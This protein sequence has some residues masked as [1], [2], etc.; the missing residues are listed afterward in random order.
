MNHK[1]ILM[2]LLSVQIFFLGCSE[3]TFT[4][5][6]TISGTERVFVITLNNDEE[7]EVDGNDEAFKFETTLKKGSTYEVIVSDQP[8]STTC[9]VANGTGTV[10]GEDISDIEITCVEE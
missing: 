9:T 10:S 3:S 5:G 2:I 6:G 1:A 4:V 7:L 8:T